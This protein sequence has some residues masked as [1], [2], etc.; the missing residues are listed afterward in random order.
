MMKIITYIHVYISLTHTHTYTSDKQFTNGWSRLAFA[1]WGNGL[2]ACVIYEL[3][4]PETGTGTSKR[5]CCSFSVRCT[6]DPMTGDVVILSSQ[7]LAFQLAS[8]S[9][10]MVSKETKVSLEMGIVINLNFQP[11]ITHLIQQQAMVQEP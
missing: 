4:L 6:R 1:S 11:H 2:K 10:S 7:L 9:L 8:K 3:L 5:D